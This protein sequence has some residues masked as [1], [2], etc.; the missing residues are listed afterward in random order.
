MQTF[1]DPT[2]AVL[3]RTLSSPLWASRRAKPG[4]GGN[5]AR[6]ERRSVRNSQDDLAELLAGLQSLVGRSGL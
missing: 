1:Q 4:S 2:L 5:C 6:L 3:A